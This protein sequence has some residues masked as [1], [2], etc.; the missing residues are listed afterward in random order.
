M[1]D[2]RLQIGQDLPA[3]AELVIIGGGIVGAATAFFAARAGLQAVVIE[4]RPLIAGHT[5]MNATGAFRAQFDNPEE[6]A[7]VREGIALFEDFANV[8]GLPGWDIGL[9]QQGYLWLATNPATATRQREQVQQQRDWGLDDVEWFDGDEAR[10]HFPYLSASVIGARY[11]SK[12][13]WLDVRRLAM[14]YALASQATFV[15]NTA[16]TGF[17]LGGGRVRGVRTTRGDIATERVV[18][19]AGPFSGVVAQLAGLDLALSLVRRQRVLLLD[20]PE[21]PADAPMTIDDETG[22]HWRPSPHGAHLMWTQPD[23]LTGPPQED[24]AT[25]ADFAFALLD[26]VSPQSVTRISPF[27]QSVWDRG[28]SH[29]YLRAGQ[30]TYTPDRRP[31]LGPTPITGLYLNTGYSGHGIMGSAGGSLLAVDTITG[32]LAP[33]QNPFRLDRPMVPRALD[34]L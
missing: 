10:R 3:T 29:W 24:V 16:V 13:G 32:A 14:G 26:P 31:F 2:L 6:M 27:W 11:R 9:C 33:E 1:P 19:A 34:V 20:V 7:L 21:V 23:E 15:L 17:D 30:Y 18:I 4:K 28:T 22:A 25:R 12:D 5:T 8:T